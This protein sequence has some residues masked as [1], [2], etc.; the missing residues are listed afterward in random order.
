[1]QCNP[2][3][4]APLGYG[5]ALGPFSTQ[6][7]MQLF[8]LA[9]TAAA[10][11]VSHPLTSDA[12]LSLAG[13]GVSLV[14]ADGSLTRLLKKGAQTIL[15]NLASSSVLNWAVAWPARQGVAAGTLEHDSRNTDH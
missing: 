8:H 2:S 13:S 15:S 4:V 5:P 10:A 11:L 3:F 14:R 6:K 1:M 7:A 9:Q 12:S